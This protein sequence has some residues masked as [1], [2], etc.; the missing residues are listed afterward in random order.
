MGFK[1]FEEWNFVGAAI[2][3]LLLAFLQLVLQLHFRA[4]WLPMIGARQPIWLNYWSLNW[5][6]LIQHRE[7]MK[8]IRAEP[9]EVIANS[10]LLHPR[11]Y[12]FLHNPSLLNKLRLKL[13]SKAYFNIGKLKMLHLL[14]E[15]EL[16]THYREE[17]EE[18][19]AT[20]GMQT[21]H[22]SVQSTALEV[23]V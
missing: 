9:D 2:F 10:G 8:P 17:R 23:M 22:L 13:H 14:G 3:S 19:D 5:Q 11:R 18:Q 12:I 6:L 15:P 16:M 20:R 4:E 1:G 7:E 21:H